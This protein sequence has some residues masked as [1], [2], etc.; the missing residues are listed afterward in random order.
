MFVADI[1]DGRLGIFRITEV[2]EKSIYKETTASVDYVLVAYADHQLNNQRYLDLEAKVVQTKYFVK[3][4]ID[5]H[6]NPYLTD[7]DYNVLKELTTHYDRLVDHYYRT[8]L[9][10]QYKCFL[11]PNQP[12][13]TYDPFLTKLMVQAF[14]SYT[15]PK[16]AYVKT[17]NVKEAVHYQTPTIWDAVYQRDPFLLLEATQRV[18][19]VPSSSFVREPLLEGIYFTGIETVVYPLNTTKTV[20][21]R[22]NCT[23]TEQQQ[24]AFFRSDDTKVLNHH[25][26]LPII[27]P[28][29]LGGYYVLSEDFYRNT[30]R[31]S[32]L[33]A[34]LKLYIESKP[35]DPSSLLTIAKDVLNWGS[36]ERFYYLP[37]VLFMLHSVKRGL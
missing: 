14:D 20:D 23:I 25:N 30:N 12:Y 4:F 3:E 28:A 27:K 22:I 36:L 2:E 9:S 18:I 26:G 37:L 13:L 33:E 1:G 35:L 5:Y 6:Q 16:A 15:H 7:Y 11:V 19:L 31:L 21:T 32:L 29:N 17:F 8:F 10:T 24:L 34:Q